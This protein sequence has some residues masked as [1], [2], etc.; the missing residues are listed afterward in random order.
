MGKIPTPEQKRKVDRTQVLE[1]RTGPWMGIP[2]LRRQHSKKAHCDK[3]QAPCKGQRESESIRWR[4]P[5]L[6]TTTERAPD[7]WN[8]NR[9]TTQGTTWALCILWI[10]L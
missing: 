2:S 6:G 4:T 10:E 8:E 7:V 5:L 9:D 1:L 3:H